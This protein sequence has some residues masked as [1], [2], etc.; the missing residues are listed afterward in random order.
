MWLH[1]KEIILYF[2]NFFY[3]SVV[4]IFKY[5]FVSYFMDIIVGRY[6]RDTFVTKEVVQR[7]KREFD[8]DYFGDKSINQTIKPIFDLKGV[9]FSSLY[10]FKKEHLDR[11]QFNWIYFI[12]ENWLRNNKDK[13]FNNSY[14]NDP[15]FEEFVKSVNFPFIEKSA[16]IKE[17]NHLITQLDIPFENI[18]RLIVRRNYECYGYMHTVNHVRKY[19]PHIKEQPLIIDVVSRSNRSIPKGIEFILR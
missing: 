6:A 11:F 14:D 4:K 12:N 8:N 3:Y 1:G 18:D 17:P 9:N 10:L 5:C 16:M 13:I 15:E 19:V 2:F 7:N